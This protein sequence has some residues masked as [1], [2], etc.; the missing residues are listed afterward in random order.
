M[1]FSKD[2]LGSPLGDTKHPN[3]I[4]VA[5]F[6]GVF[7]TAEKIK[8][9]RYPHQATAPAKIP[10]KTQAMTRRAP[11]FRTMAGTAKI[12]AA[13]ARQAAQPINVPTPITPAR[14]LWE[15]HRKPPAGISSSTHCTGWIFLSCFRL[16]PCTSWEFQNITG[17]DYKRLYKLYKKPL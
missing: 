11:P 6:G 17:Y 13:P 3:T 4:T 10:V 2:R 5:E 9:E 12:S 16:I 15:N 8:V 7:S 1:R 14:R